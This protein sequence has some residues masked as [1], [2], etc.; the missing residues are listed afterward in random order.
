MSCLTEEKRMSLASLKTLQWPFSGEMEHELGYGEDLVVP[1]GF[2]MEL[3]SCH[4]IRLQSGSR[5][6]VEQG[7][8]LTAV[9]PKEILRDEST[10]VRRC[11][12]LPY[13]LWLEDGAEIFVGSN[14]VLQSDLLG[15]YW[16]AA[17]CPIN[18]NEGGTLILEKKAMTIAKVDENEGEYTVVEGQLNGPAFESDSTHPLGFSEELRNFLRG[19][20]GYKQ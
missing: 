15:L 6:L 2:Q 9:C 7:A 19:L 20:D 10:D 3:D 14:A 1:S 12:T 18:L 11:S 13:P 16:T 4:R 8:V 17:S 5:L